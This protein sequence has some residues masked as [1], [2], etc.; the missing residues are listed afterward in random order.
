[1]VSKTNDYYITV[2]FHS[3]LNLLKGMYTQVETSLNATASL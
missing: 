3:N 2:I 1:M